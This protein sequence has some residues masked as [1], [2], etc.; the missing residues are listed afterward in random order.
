[1]SKKAILMVL[2]SLISISA[3]ADSNN[4]L[5]NIIPDGRGNLN[6]TNNSKSILHVDF[7]RS[8]S[9]HSSFNKELNWV[10]MPGKT[11]KIKFNVDRGL[12]ADAHFDGDL[13]CEFDGSAGFSGL[14]KM[15]LNGNHPV[16]HFETKIACEAAANM[17]AG[18][19]YGNFQNISLIADLSYDIPSSQGTD[20]QHCKLD[21]GYINIT[22]LNSKNVAVD[23]KA[24]DVLSGAEYGCY[25]ESVQTPSDITKNVLSMSASLFSDST[26]LSFNSDLRAP[27]K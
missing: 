2:I 27:E 17:E 10:I 7:D 4:N 18:A 25:Y 8:Y 14:Y 26:K 3:V 5:S 20:A 13:T 12:T 23:I 21:G 19:T 22:T 24:P 15:I 6:I 1:M 11:Q 16:A 9:K